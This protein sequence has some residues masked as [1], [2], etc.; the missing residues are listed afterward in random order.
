M[1]NRITLLVVFFLFSVSLFSQ[2]LYWIGGNGNWSDINHWSEQSGGAVANYLPNEN[3]TIIFDKNSSKNKRLSIKLNNLVVVKELKSSVSTSLSGLGFLAAQRISSKINTANIHTDLYE[4]ATRGTFEIKL[5]NTDPSCYGICDGTITVDVES[6][7]PTYPVT[8]RVYYPSDLG[9]GNTDYNN[10]NSLPY[11]ISDLCG[12]SQ[13]YTIRVTDKDGDKKYKS[14]GLTAPGKMIIDESDTTNNSCNG[15]CD[16]EIQIDYIQ[17]AKYPIKHYNWSNGDTT[18]NPTN[19]CAGTYTLA[20]EDDNGCKDTFSFPITEPPAISIDSTFYTKHICYGDTGRIYVE[21]SG[22]S[23]SLSYAI[24]T[25][26]QGTGNF[27]NLTAGTYSVT[28]VDDSNCTDTAGP[29]ELISNPQIII[30]DSTRDLRCYNDT[31]GNIDITVSGGYPDYTYEWSGPANFTSNTDDISD[32]IAGVYQLTVTDSVQCTETFTDSVKQP[33]SLQIKLDSLHN[34]SCNGYGDGAIWDTVSGGTIPYGYTWDGPGG[35]SSSNEDINSLEAG[36]YH[37]TI[38]DKNHCKQY[39]SATITEPDPMIITIDT[40]KNISCNGGSNG[41]IALTVTDGTTPYVYNWSGPNGF[42]STN[43]DISGLKAGTYNFTVTD[44]SG[45]EKTTSITLTEPNAINVTIDSIKPVTCNGGNDGAVT[46]SVSDGTS[47]YTFHW[48]GPNSYDSTA[49]DIDNLTAGKYY[50][51]VSD[52]NH[53]EKYDSAIVTEPVP[54]KI[55]VDSINNVSCYGGNNASIYITASDGIT[56]YHYNWDGPHSYSSTNEDITGLEAGDYLVTVEDQNHCK[57][58]D[59]L[60]VVEPDPI[61]ITID[62]TKNISCNGGSN[63][64]IYITATKGTPGYSYNWQGPSGYS[65]SNEDITGLKAGTYYLTVTDT[66]SCEQYDTA[67]ITEPNPIIITTDSSNNISCNGLGDGNIYISVSAGTKPYTYNWSGPNGYSATSDDITGLEAGTYNLTVTD[68]SHCQETTSFTIIEPDTISLVVDSTKNVSCDGN[69]GAVYI[70]VT[71]GTTPYSYHW[72]GP[73]S[74]TSSNEDITGLEAGDYYITVDDKNHCKKYDTVTVNSDAPIIVSVDD[75]HNVSCNGN[76]DGSIQISVSGGTPGYTYD[77]SNPNGYSSHNEDIAL[78]YANSYSIRITDHDG[79]K[80]T[81]TID[82]TEPEEIEITIDSIKNISC[83]GK[84]DGAIYITASKGTPG[85]VYKW[86]GPDNYSSTNSDISGLKDGIYYLT[87]TDTNNCEK[88]D[89]VTITDPS[90]III[91]IDQTTPV[92][93]YGGSNGAI[94]TTTTGGTTPYTYSWS[95]P[96]GYSATTDDISGLKAG[97]YTINVSDSNNCN[98]SSVVT[99]TQPDSINIHFTI[100]NPSC[101]NDCDGEV[102]ASVLGGTASYSYLW[103][104]GTTDSTDK[105]LCAGNDT[106]TITD[107]HA[108]HKT[109]IATL[110]N[111]DGVIA[112]F[113]SK[114]DPLCYGDST[115]S[116][117][118][119]TSGG[120]PGYTYHWTNTNVTS[121]SVNNSLPTGSYTVTVVDSRNCQDTANFSLTSPGQ[122][123]GDIT[124]NAKPTCVGLCDGNATANVTGGTTPYSYLWNSGEITQTA[125]TLCAGSTNVTIT[126]SNHCQLVIDTTIDAP[127]VVTASIPDSTNPSCYG[128]C[129]GTA[130]AKGSG[131]TTP[132]TYLWSSGHTN[133]TDTGLCAGTIQVTVYDHNNCKDTASITLYSPDS[134][135]VTF[136]KKEPKCYGDAN[137]SIT[138]HVTGGTKDYVFNWSTGATDSTATN[139]TADT[140]TVTIT[141]HHNCFRI[142]TVILNQ[143]KELTLSIDSILNP[144]CAGDANGKVWLFAE[145]GTGPYTYNWSTGATDSVVSGLLANTYGATVTDAGGCT[146]NKVVIL[147]EPKVLTAND[148]VKDIVCYGECNGKAILNPTGGTRPFSYLWDANAGGGT[149][150]IVTNLC[151]GTYTALISDAHG[152]TAK[153]TITITQPTAIKIKIDSTKDSYCSLCTGYTEVSVTGGTSPYALHWNTGATTSTLDSLCPDIYHLTVT[154]SNGC[155]DSIQVTIVDTSDMHVVINNIHGVSCNGTCDGSANAFASGGETPYTYSW[156]TSPVCTDSTATNLCATTYEVTVSDKNGCSRTKSVTIDD[157]DS[158]TVSIDATPITCSNKCDGSIRL[159]ISGGSPPYSITWADGNTDSNRTDLCSGTYHFTV[160]DNNTCSQID[161][162]SLNNPTLLKDTIFSIAGIVCFGDST[163]KIQITATG[164]SSP[165]AY[166]WSNNDHDTLAENLPAGMHYVTVTDSTG[167]TITDSLELSQPPQLKDTIINV[168]QVPC[169]AACTASAQ[170]S[171]S[172]GTPGYSYQWSNGDT[173][174]TADSLCAGYNYVTISDSYHCIYIDTVVITDTS[175]L[176]LK[177]D[178]ISP[179][180]CFGDTNGQAIVIA[181]GGSSPYSFAWDSLAHYQTSDTANNLGS[182]HYFVTLTDGDNC[183]RTLL[184]NVPDGEKINLK[185]DSGIL[186]TCYNASSGYLSVIASG[187]TPQYS[188]VWNTGDSSSVADS[189]NDGTFTVTVT[190]SKGCSSTWDTTITMNPRLLL[191]LSSHSP[192]CANNTHDGSA[193][194]TISGGTPGYS[195][196][197]STH[198]TTLQIDS[199]DGG[200]YFIT[201]TDSLGCKVT[202]STEIKPSIVVWAK[203]QY[204]TTICAGDT[205]QLFG[206]GSTNNFEWAPTTHMTDTLLWKPTVAPSDTTIYTLTV[207]DSIC[208]AVDSVIITTFPV[209]P[210]DAGND[211]EIMHDHDTQLE[212]TGLPSSATIV[213][214]PDSSLDNSSIAN[215]MAKPS[216]TT[217]YIVFVTDSNHCRVSDTVVV[218]VIPELFV[219]N[220]FTPNGDGKNDVWEIDYINKFPNVEVEVYNRWGERIFYSK[221]YPDNERWDGTYNGKKLPT[222]TYYFIINL[223]DKIIT[224]PITGPI[225]IVR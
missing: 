221:G 168:D 112:T 56:P 36:D 121:D 104:T 97:D 133:S 76:N 53:C 99:I 4:T 153:D 57:Q 206:S 172:G 203:A 139:L 120:T 101:H 67:T 89:T 68:S 103:S 217:T 199:L 33:D 109:A 69:D 113:I 16:G 43:D 74:Y 94:S 125:D 75:V 24:D 119:T 58:Y 200:T 38:E 175:D 191:L 72:E 50:L 14:I 87:V 30:D 216:E 161:S 46:I 186:Q 107:A 115:G 208:V 81:L 82:V 84:T 146:D 184:I 201:V 163:G 3:T 218:T 5:S 156:N 194:A 105:N 114:K 45:C 60:T 132:Y 2:T 7:S 180:I 171:A 90:P 213:W 61:K 164:G 17:N 62:S 52:K 80:K 66:N 59:T 78:L 95:G 160:T 167:C 136:E 202:D 54:V 188:Y 48:T 177:V 182:N 210:I 42:T 179:P 143:P 96:N 162:V 157:K 129:D 155:I 144:L 137:G 170:A 41:S 135:A 6:G 9:G 148:S 183:S 92:N 27:P 150:S 166:H 83:S 142:D 174:A 31:S 65:S 141:D 118:L 73:F 149:D 123:T 15:T 13:D 131:G 77:W 220:G 158:I 128:K 198:D 124:I 11:T 28:V 176:E 215:P 108:C 86:S 185:L 37:L 63:G 225:T 196:Y 169:G 102:T 18:D 165:Y 223:H 40:A 207:H 64:A 39:Y 26:K 91:T 98:T 1:R 49:E 159:H 85:Y 204:D 209:A 88:Y 152:C 93:C 151:E 181:N 47:P 138:A 134:L 35:Y 100:T 205:V 140:F 178:S 211:I 12:A 29:F 212:V 34:I 219:P 10:I 190:D 19:L 44:S 21:A 224:K 79:C 187:G 130:T 122:L 214:T 110:I 32:L 23:G 197:W 222:G 51:T 106:I 147:V 127:I 55:T 126:D 25:N 145:G 154:D 20:V 70:T 193:V 22:G 189:L 192:L 173:I 71:N 195:T 116:A 117:T 8:I 111:P